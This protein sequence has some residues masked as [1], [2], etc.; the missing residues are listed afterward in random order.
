[1]NYKNT[2]IRKIR[3]DGREKGKEQSDFPIEVIYITM[4]SIMFLKTESWELD[5]FEEQNEKNSAKFLLCNLKI[6]IPKNSDFS[7]TLK[8]FSLL[9]NSVNYL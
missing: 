4:T 9:F 3:C 7:F 6:A 8:V 2:E 1:M 5:I